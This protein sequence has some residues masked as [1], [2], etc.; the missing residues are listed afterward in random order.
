MTTAVNGAARETKKRL[1]TMRARLTEIAVRAL[2]PAA[3]KQLKVWDTTTPGFGVRVNGH[4]KSWIVMY[5]KAR[6]LKVLGR[7]PDMPLAEARRQAKLVLLGE[8]HPEVASL[9]FEEAKT[10]FLAAVEKRNKPRTHKD[11]ARL[12]KRHFDFGRVPLSEITR[13]DI[14]RK[15]DKLDGTPSE[16]AHAFAALKI[17]LRWALKRGHIDRSPME[18][19]EVPVKGSPR[20]RVLT[21]VELRAVFRAARAY[22]HPFGPIVQLLILT[23]Q[24]RSEV[25]ALRW[26]WIDTEA[27]TITLPESLTKNKTEHTFPYAGMVAALLEH[28]PRTGDYLFPA[29]RE[30]VQGKPATVFNGWGKPKAALDRRLEDVAPYTLHDLRRTFSTQ[31]ASLGVPQHVV[32]RILNHKPGAHTAISPIAVLYNHYRCM[33]EMRDAVTKWESK[34]TDMSDRFA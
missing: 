4:S 29:A 7:F 25:A 28:V 22:P 13:S 21:D 11:Y 17:F 30:R 16:Q 1:K 18:N 32:E 8:N 23:G 31:L 33:D 6:R 26:E 3:G 9:L 20:R 10:A 19:M 5:G 27:R 2:K 15:L 34:L 12:L 14:A 24:R